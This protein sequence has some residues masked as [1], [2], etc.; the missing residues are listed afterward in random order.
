MFRDFLD[1][2]TSAS[3][4]ALIDDNRRPSTI[5]DDAGITDFRTS[6]TCDLDGELPLVAAVRRQLSALMGIPLSHAEPLHD[7]PRAA[8]GLRRLRVD[9]V[10]AEPLE[11]QAEHGARGLGC[12]ALAPAIGAQLP[13]DFG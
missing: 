5:A 7:T 2:E 9:D 12:V 11:H 13:A 8:I 4:C 1:V 3:L 6:E 10:V